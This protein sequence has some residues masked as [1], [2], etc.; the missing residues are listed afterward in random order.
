LV[1]TEE[2][3]AVGVGGASVGVA[4]DDTGIAV[5]VGKRGRIGLG[6]SVG[7]GWTV[8]PGCGT[9]WLVGLDRPT[10]SGIGVGRKVTVGVG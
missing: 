6:R 1:G 9:S 8:A 10:A 2:S 5:K 4:V 3:T 7:D